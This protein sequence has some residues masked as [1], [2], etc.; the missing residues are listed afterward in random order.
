LKTNSGYSVRHA[1]RAA[2][3]ATVPFAGSPRSVVFTG[4]VVNA[5]RRR[6]ST[7]WIEAL[8][9]IVSCD[10][11]RIFSVPPLTLM[12]DE[13]LLIPA[14][15]KLSVPPLKV[16]DVWADPIV[17]LPEPDLTRADPPEI[18]VK[19]VAAPSVRGRFNVAAKLPPL[20]SMDPLAVVVAELLPVKF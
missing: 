20:E 1:A 14:P 10:P 4:R 19:F 17:K 5:E 12:M 13:L 7:L 8:A 9:A 18:E 2:S 6:F 15:P 3:I 11:A 16:L